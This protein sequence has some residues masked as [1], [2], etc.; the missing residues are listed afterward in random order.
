MKLPCPYCGDWIKYEESLGGTSITCNYC[1][2]P[3]LMP[4]VAQLPPDYQE[5]F[6]QEQDK[7]LKKAE[8]AERKRLLAEKRA[9]DKKQAEVLRQQQI[10]KRAKDAEA[11]REA[12]I[13]RQQQIAKAVA[14]AQPTPD[15]QPTTAHSKKSATF[16]FAGTGIG[17]VGT[18]VVIV[19]FAVYAA[20]H[21]VNGPLQEVISNDPRNKGVEARAYYGDISQST[22]I[23]DLR[24]VSENNSRADVFRVLLHYAKAMKEK[25]FE[26]VQLAWR[27]KVKFVANGAYFQKLG[28]EFDS[29]NPVYT[30]RTFPENLRTPSGDRAFSEW[31]GGMLGVLKAQMDDFNHFHD[32][33]YLDDLVRNP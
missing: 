26:S 8:L 28:E 7:L 13:A 24:G 2:R 22:L 27:G 4:V 17:G 10:E 21:V 5:E 30:I 1:R 15:N 20:N 23:F 9:A 31:T 33:W 16:I 18:I 6:R 29:Q 32:Q 11:Q 25:R 12:E 19:I 14:D 3:I